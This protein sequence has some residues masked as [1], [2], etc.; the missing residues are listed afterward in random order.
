[1]R[2]ILDSMIRLNHW[3]KNWALKKL[4][5]S[6]SRLIFGERMISSETKWWNRNCRGFNIPTNK[7][8]A[9]HQIHAWVVPPATKSII[10]LAPTEILWQNAD[11]VGTNKILSLLRK[12]E[13]SIFRSSRTS[14]IRS[15]A[16]PSSNS[17][18]V[19]NNP[20]SLPFYRQQHQTPTSMVFHQC[21]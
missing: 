6:E 9:Y 5:C 3:Q 4:I 10:L 21:I 8:V 16:L 20:S 7:D 11:Q 12:F 19:S 2:V 18:N 17:I 14:S 15:F 1:L 13:G